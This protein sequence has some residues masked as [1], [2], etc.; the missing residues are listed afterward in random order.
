MDLRYTVKQ[1]NQ[2]NMKYFS[3]HSLCYMLMNTFDH[4]PV[5]QLTSPGHGAKGSHTSSS[6]GLSV[7]G[8]SASWRAICSSSERERTQMT[9]RLRSP[10][11]L[12]QVMEQ[13]CQ[14][15]THHLKEA[16]DINEIVL[17]KNSTQ[18]MRISFSFCRMLQSSLQSTKC[19]LRVRN[20]S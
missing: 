8:Q 17:R 11:P 5:S 4:V 9:V 14:G 15:P 7:T 19:R 13:C 20:K 3:K 10:R 18:L 16:K 6:V 1:N 2:K 12:P